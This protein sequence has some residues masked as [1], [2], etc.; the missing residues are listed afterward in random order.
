MVDVDWWTIFE[1]GRAAQGVGPLTIA[2]HLAR[3]VPADMVI[4]IQGRPW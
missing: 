3:G 1:P 4:L 2:A